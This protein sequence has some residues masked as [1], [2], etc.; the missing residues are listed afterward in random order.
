LKTSVC[1]G[2]TNEEDKMEIEGQF[3]AAL[4]L[5]QQLTRVVVEKITS[6]EKEKLSKESYESPAWAY[7]QADFNGYKRAMLEII[8]L[9]EN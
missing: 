8:S 9:L 2:L 3:I 4:R 1:K 5:R 7:K 6:Y